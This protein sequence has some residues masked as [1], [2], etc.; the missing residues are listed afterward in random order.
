MCALRTWPSARS[1]ACAGCT[2]SPRVW[3][4]RVFPWLAI[5]L[6]CLSAP[7]AAQAQS[8]L[9]VLDSGAS[10]RFSQELVFW[11]Q[12]EAETPVQDVILFYGIE[13]ARLVRRIYPEFTPGDSLD[14]EHR[15]TIESGQFAPG[16]R[17][18][19]WWRL[20]LANG[21]VVD[22]PQQVLDY[23]D[24]ARAWQTLSD[25]RVDLHWYGGRAA[26]AQTLLQRATEALTRLEDELDLVSDRR[27]QV[28]VYANE[29]D[30]L[31]ALA[32]RSDDFD[33]RVTTL[34][35][36][37]AEH[38]LVL[39]GNH[40]DVERTLAHELSH[41][42]VGLA[43]DNPYAGLPRWLDEGL[44]MVAEGELRTGNARALERAI[45][46][47][48]LLSVRSM[49]SYSG[50]VEEVDLFYG[51]SHSVVTY[52]LDTYGQPK[53]GQLLRVFAQGA[54]QDV[55]LRQVYGFGLDELD[56]RWR[57]SLGLEPRDSPGDGARS[58]RLAPA[59]A[60]ARDV[61]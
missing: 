28:F 19:Y 10:Y 25:G 21:A 16:T 23:T 18:R 56:A 41:I 53:M 13:G 32:T 37:V 34:G 17:L 12:A 15:E 40:P 24:D 57:A 51:A 6:L 7:V 45:R 55:A 49:S 11:I 38:T 46:N 20:R 43:T 14:I 9:S 3:R 35:V 1:S 58:W 2:F 60:A 4:A 5:L 42:V 39:L 59:V 47:D 50:R 33:A 30:M 48:A 36:V 27:I 8:P 52:L 54:L 26:Q 31:P 44:A 61:R 29:R 22:T